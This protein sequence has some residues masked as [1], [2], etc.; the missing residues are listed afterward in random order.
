MAALQTS[1]GYMNGACDHYTQTNGYDGCAKAGGGVTTDLWNTDR[2]GVGLNGTYG[3]F[4]YVGRAVET[5]TQHDVA[6][7]APPLFYYLAMQCAHDVRH[8]ALPAPRPPAHACP[9]LITQA[10]IPECWMWCTVA[11]HGSWA[12]SPPTLVCTHAAH[13][14]ATALPGHLR[15][16]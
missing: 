11:D 15:Q 3:D 13:G 6:E 14:G 8:R 7:N 16:G 1:L 12:E 10:G 4:M 9:R 2:P 5:I